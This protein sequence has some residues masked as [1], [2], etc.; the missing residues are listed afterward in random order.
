ME[1]TI[2]FSIEHITRKCFSPDIKNVLVFVVSLLLLFSCL[3]ILIK[4]AKS[5]FNA[6]CRNRPP[7]IIPDP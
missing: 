5:V 4:S 7:Y 3:M 2:N 1:R 6:S